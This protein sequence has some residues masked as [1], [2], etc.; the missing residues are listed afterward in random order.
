MD[1]PIHREQFTDYG[2]ITGGFSMDV[3]TF[4]QSLKQDPAYAGQIVHVHTEPARIPRW[5]P[6]PAGLHPG[7]QHFLDALEVSRLYLH[8]AEAIEAALKGQDILITMGAA[9]GKS[10]CYQVPIVQ[11][12][13]QH[14]EATALFVF[15]TKALA[16]DQVAS[17]NRGVEALRNFINP[18]EVAAM[19]FDADANAADRRMA[20]DSARL[21][22]TNPEMLHANLLPGH[23][24]WGKFFQGLR[25]VV[26]DEV[27]TYTGFFGANM[28]N[29]L[30]RLERVCAHYGSQPQFICSSAT[31]GNPKEMAELITGHSLYHVDEDTS[32]AGSRTYIFW[33]PPRIKSRNWRSRRS[34]NVEAHELM[35]K[36]IRQRISTICFS[37]ARNTAEMI[38]RYVRETL[39]TK[40][41]ALADRVIPYR[42]GYS[43]KERRDMER[44]LRE[45]ELLGVSATRA[46]ELGID[47]GALEACIV[48]GYPG[49]LN[50]FF[51]QTG[52]AGRAGR[53]A[54]CIL[55]GT[56][57][58]IN[59]YIMNHPEFI[60]DR[61]IEQ[62]VV[63]CD[64]PFVV[65][66]HLRCAT[67]EL[68]VTES[69]DR[70][71]GYATGFALEVLEEEQKVRRIGGAWY[72][73]SAEQPAHEVRLRGYGDESTVIMDADTGN[74][75]D[76]LDKFRALRI[77]YPGAIYFH[78]GDTYAMVQHDTERNVVQVRR[79]D[80]SYYTDPVT[81]TSVDHV[82]AVLDQRP[83]GAGQA[84]LGEVF[85]VLSTPLYEKV[86]FYTMDRISQH[87]TDVPPVAYEAM[88][89]WLTTPPE[90]PN[91]VGKLG[92]N[93]ES[94]MK[95]I[96]YCISRVLPLFLTSDVNDF[97]WSL[98]CRNTPWHTMF[99]YEFYL[100]GIGHAE[101]CYE[102]LEEIL[103]VA[104]EHLLTC[105]CEDG[106]PN[107]TSRL[108][109][110]YHVRNI[111][112]GEGII[113]SRRAAVVVLNSLLTGQSASESLMLL[114]EPREKRGQKFLPTITGERRQQKPHKMPLNERTRRLML[115]K[116]ERTRSPKQPVDHPIEP[117]PPVG[118][119]PLEKKRM[120][121]ASDSE[122]RSGQQAIRR[123]GDPFSRR[124]REL[125]VQSK[126]PKKRK[127][128]ETESVSS[129]DVSPS[130]SIVKSSNDDTVIQA[131]DPIARRARKLKRKK[132]N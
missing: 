40:E 101:Q 20:R 5:A 2:S 90:L 31:V 46:L 99:W 7:V 112:L 107:C 42:G 102:R 63:D 15:P 82:D 50:A 132:F 76:R 84:Y 88:S 43:P 121:V 87:P 106:C 8:Q 93:P 28:A 59:Q 1:L 10:L 71:F 51:Q 24:R 95:G 73:A 85:A 103:A 56:D 37:K 67:A 113:A 65:L 131:G 108:I 35:V 110:P 49:T 86:R 114:D 124:L 72:H 48:V 119:P 126:Q 129:E 60:F 36:L 79:V 17:W 11:A 62:A 78:R 19:P 32:A 26:L 58:A 4:L 98:G 39:Q 64:N 77:F 66:G 12:I 16:R 81:G 118:I 3:D 13:L 83:L 27:H 70:R 45:G 57:T 14:P 6:L 117:T 29:V 120:L 109:T 55:V 61:P 54:L 23:V 38:Y 128:V 47:V 22:V 68:P 122:K 34:A 25:F 94:G 105:D 96:L 75:I 41:P 97:D 52:R 123:A 89:F 115:R 125:D 127:Q 111:E 30:R 33:N 18:Q 69:D 130:P 21:L 80:V 74:V 116:V 104:L 53:D 44:R 9:S 91:E 92:M 100:H